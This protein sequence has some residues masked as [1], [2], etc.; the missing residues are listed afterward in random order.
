MP[1]RVDGSR[2]PR[3]SIARFRTRPRSELARTYADLITPAGLKD[4]AQYAQG[5]GAHKN[6]VVP[7]DTSGR[8]LSPTTLVKDAHAA[9]L[10]VHVWTFRNEDFFLPSDMKGNPAAE[11]ALFLGLGIDGMFSDYPDAAV[12]AREAAARKP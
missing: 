1:R 6:L 2:S 7:R 3:A 5:I 11:Y 8:S 9:G 10:R 4:I 12:R